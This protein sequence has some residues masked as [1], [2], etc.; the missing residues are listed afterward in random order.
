VL[1]ARYG[2]AAIRGSLQRL[3]V[4]GFGKLGGSELNFSSDIDLVLAY[5]QGG[6]S[7]GSR[8]LDNSEYFVRWDANWC[9]C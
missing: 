6:Q 1:A 3:V 2:I 8:P 9:A 7:D 4:I 5:P